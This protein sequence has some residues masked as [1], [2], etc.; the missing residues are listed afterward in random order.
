MIK[1]IEMFNGNH[2]PIFGL[3]TWQLRGQQCVTAVKEALEMGYDHIDTADAYENHTQIRAAL[4]TA[5]REK[6]FITTK[7][8]KEH[9]DQPIKHVERY[10]DEL[11]V[12]YLDLVLLHWPKQDAPMAESLLKIQEMDCVKSVGVSNFSIEL[13]KKVMSQGFKPVT[14]QVEFHIYLYHD[15]LLAFCRQND[16]V[17]TAYSPLARGKVIRDPLLTRIGEKHAASAVQTALAWIL[18]KNAIAIPKASSRDHLQENLDA[19]KIELS[20]DEIAEIDALDQA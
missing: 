17:L 18:S 3:G 20:E 7:I 10:L 12:E 5:E 19:I 2:I 8:P 9:L 15:E 13:L 14:N 11:G 4:Q 6:I 16:I 1:R